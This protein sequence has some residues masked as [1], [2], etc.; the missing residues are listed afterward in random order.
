MPVRQDPYRRRQSVDPR[1]SIPP[2]GHGGAGGVEHRR[3]IGRAR[4]AGLAVPRVGHPQRIAVVALTRI[5]K[6]KRCLAEEIGIAAL[7]PVSH[8]RDPATGLRGTGFERALVDIAVGGVLLHSSLVVVH[9][10]PVVRETHV[11][12]QFMRERSAAALPSDQAEGAWQ[13]ASGKVGVVDHQGHEVGADPV[14]EVMHTVDVAVRRIAESINVD[15]GVACF[16]VRHL[17]ARGQR[18]AVTHP[19]RLV[20]PV[21]LGD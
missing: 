5:G 17:L 4:D 15:P 3:R 18:H 14:A 1:R 6:A 11:V 10:P 12:S 9:L 19:A 8:Y 20:G 13:F 21:G 7:V 2:Q 16:D